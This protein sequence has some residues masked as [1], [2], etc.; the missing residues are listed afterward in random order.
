M[1]VMIKTRTFKSQFGYS[2]GSSAAYVVA[3]NAVSHAVGQT[4]LLRF[5]MTIP[6]GS[7]INSATLTLRIGGKNL[8]TGK[9]STHTVR[10]HASGDSP[11]LRPGVVEHNRPQTSA[12]V[13]WTP[14]WPASPP[15]EVLS[16]ADVKSILQEILGRSDFVTGG[17]VTFMITCTNENGSDMDVQINNDFAY[18]PTLQV[19]YT[20]PVTDTRWDFNRIENSE[21]NPTLNGLDGANAVPG[22]GQNEFYGVGAA[23]ANQGTL[24][25]DTT[26][27]R[28]PGVPTMR[29]TTGPPPEPNN[30][31]TGPY[32]AWR[33]N[34]Y[35]STIF[36]GWIYVA[37][38]VPTTNII[39]A[40]EAFNGGAQI[41]TQRGQW[42]PFC[43]S[44]FTS[45]SGAGTRWWSVAM[46]PYQQGLQFWISE[47]TMLVS[48]FRQMPFNGLT[49][50][51]T[52]IG[53]SVLINH[54]S[55]AGAQQSVRE[56]VPR[57][58]IKKYGVLMRAPRYIK[59][60]DGIL[61]LAEPIKGGPTVP[62]MPAVAISTYPAGKTISEL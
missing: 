33:T 23:A 34:A 6:K 13:T 20:E 46:R 50:D 55:T 16:S 47:P 41:I 12:G 57:T 53:G 21:F 26:F 28:V 9:Y 19:D 62:N 11:L 60:T 18:G 10:A 32:S 3:G 27:T 38:N 8:A 48:T 42:V 15:E 58:A 2:T 1:T 22:W 52:D 44:V 31:L 43:T 59:R 61:Q 24:A 29:F 14:T 39:Y 17:Y 7:T 40:Q 5:A 45:G 25:V 35:E 4:I 37:A 30:R 49:P 36:C 56:W 54:R 51:I